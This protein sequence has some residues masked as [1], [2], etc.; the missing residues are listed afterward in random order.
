MKALNSPGFLDEPNFFRYVPEVH[1]FHLPDGR[2]LTNELIEEMVHQIE[3][4]A[5]YFDSDFSED[6]EEDDEWPNEEDVADTEPNELV[7]ARKIA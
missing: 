5:G 4:E 6:D 7:G 1:K 3:V 2:L